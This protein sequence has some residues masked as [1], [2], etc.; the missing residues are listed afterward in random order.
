MFF[1]IINKLAED[2]SLHPNSFVYTEQ[3][4]LHRCLIP[5]FILYRSY[6]KQQAPNEKSLHGHISEIGI[7]T[8]SQ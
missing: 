3:R 1:Y 2:V 7:I 5:L 6:N 8:Q 4:G